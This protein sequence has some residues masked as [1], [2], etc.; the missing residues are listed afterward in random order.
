VP[1]LKAP[2]LEIQAKHDTVSGD[3]I[4]HGSVVRGQKH[5]YKFA[6]R[7]VP[8]LSGMRAMEHCLAF[9][10]PDYPSTVYVF[11]CPTTNEKMI[12]TLRP[13]ARVFA[14]IDSIWLHR[15]PSLEALTAMIDYCG[16]ANPAHH[17]FL[18]TVSAA[19]SSIAT[20]GTQ[21]PAAIPRT[22]PTPTAI[23]LTMVVVAAV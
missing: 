4:L 18:P 19:R 23:A 9:S 14:S 1:L 5:S 15:G 22:P 8:C 3:Y 6:V 10:F 16:P 11:D 21:R 12:V 2:G 20:N 7:R 17:T 13:A